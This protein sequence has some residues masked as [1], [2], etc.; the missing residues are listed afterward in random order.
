MPRDCRGEAFRLTFLHSGFRPEPPIRRQVSRSMRSTT[1]VITL[2]LALAALGRLAGAHTSDAG[3]MTMA[4]SGHAHGSHTADGE[5]CHAPS[6]PERM[7]CDTGRSECPVM[8][9]CFTVSLA[10]VVV[11]IEYRLPDNAVP[12]APHRVEY[13]QFAPVPDSPP[14]RA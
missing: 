5:D 4:S 6:A 12:L 14:P 1:R 2:L 3:A 8:A 10:S 9:S 11:P 7:P 13:A